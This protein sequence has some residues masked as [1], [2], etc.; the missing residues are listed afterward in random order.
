MK[1]AVLLISA[2]TAGCLTPEGLREDGANRI[3]ETQKST[4]EFAEC[5]IDKYQG[6]LIRPA[7]SPRSKGGTIEF[8]YQ[9]TIANNAMAALD[10]EDAGDRRRI[11]VYFRAR[12]KDMNRNIEA[13]L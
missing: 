7:F 5:L 1:K 8:N 4:L 11:K 13:C 2:L 10:I 3:V 9:T 6:K 12:D